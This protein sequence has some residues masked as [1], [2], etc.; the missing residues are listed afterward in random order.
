VDFVWTIFDDYWT[1]H[2][3]EALLSTELNFQ[4]V[5]FSVSAPKGVNWMGWERVDLIGIE[6]NVRIEQ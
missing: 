2:Y 6:R 4:S 1:Q 5:F 3:V